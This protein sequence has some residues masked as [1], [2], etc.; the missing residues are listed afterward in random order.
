MKRIVALQFARYWVL[1]NFQRLQNVLPK[2]SW[3]S[4]SPEL[5]LNIWTLTN[6]MFVDLHPVREVLGRKC[7]A[8]DTRYHL[9]VYSDHDFCYMPESWPNEEN[10]PWY[11]G[12][13]V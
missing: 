9:R 5:D 11:K 3:E 2:D 7:G 13:K 10:Y 4:L 8:T 1:L 6:W 12:E